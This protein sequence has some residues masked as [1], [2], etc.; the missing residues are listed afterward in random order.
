MLIEDQ[1]Y[2]WNE[3]PGK[4]APG[5]SFLLRFREGEEEIVL[6]FDTSRRL[7]QLV[8]SQQPV[9]MGRMLGQLEKYLGLGSPLP[10]TN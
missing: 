2:R 6:A 10:A 5:W 9:V 1:S 4:E 7:V 3:P 8:G